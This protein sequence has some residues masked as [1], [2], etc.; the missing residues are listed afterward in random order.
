MGVGQPRR[1]QDGFQYRICFEAVSQIQGDSMVTHT[2]AR[3]H[4]HTHTAHMARLCDEWYAVRC[5]A[6]NRW[7]KMAEVVNYWSNEARAS[8]DQ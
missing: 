8:S 5:L 6:V 2:R 1:L 7:S 4:T 3:A